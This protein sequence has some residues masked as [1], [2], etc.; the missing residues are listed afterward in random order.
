[1]RKG[2]NSMKAA[3]LNLWLNICLNINNDNLIHKLSALLCLPEPIKIKDTRYAR[4]K[5]L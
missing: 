5:T 4:G 3:I 2:V 1:M